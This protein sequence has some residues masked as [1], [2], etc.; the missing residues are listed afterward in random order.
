MQLKN[1]LPAFY[2][3]GTGNDVVGYLRGSG[4]GAVWQ[5][6]ANTGSG[7]MMVLGSV[8][9]I[10]AEWAA[11]GKPSFSYG[12]IQTITRSTLDGFR[13]TYGGFMVCRYSGFVYGRPWAHIQIETDDAGSAGFAQAL[14]SWKRN[15]QAP[16]RRI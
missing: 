1:A 10:A 11:A 14:Q 15:Y 16:K 3:S 4:S 7:Q 12:S 5:K 9:P 6:M 13:L 8:I 2:P